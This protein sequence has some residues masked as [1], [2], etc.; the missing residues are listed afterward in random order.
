[1]WTFDYVICDSLSLCFTSFCFITITSFIVSFLFAWRIVTL[2]QGSFVASSLKV[3]RK[4]YLN[5]TLGIF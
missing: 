3:F 2:K 5:T 1:M 4:K